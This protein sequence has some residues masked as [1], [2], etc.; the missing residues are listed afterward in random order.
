[1]SHWRFSASN[2]MSNSMTAIPS[3]TVT[4]PEGK[5]YVLTVFHVPMTREMTAQYLP[6]IK[7]LGETLRTPAFLFDARGA[8]DRRE[9]FEDYEIY[10]FANWFGFFGAKIAVIIGPGDRSYDFT[11]TVANNAGYRH[12]LFTEESEALRWLEQDP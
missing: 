1:M 5:S 10:E 8:P 12:R 6:E 3:F 2:G 7:K 11:D 4:V 9:I